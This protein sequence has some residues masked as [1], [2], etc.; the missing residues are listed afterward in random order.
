[1]K[2]FSNK[3]PAVLNLPVEWTDEDWA[4]PLVVRTPATP[5]CRNRFAAPRLPL[6]R[7]GRPASRYRQGF[8][9]I[10]LLVVISIIALLAALL[11]PVL[12]KVKEKSKITL[13]R[14]DMRTI[15]S[16]IAQYQA[17]YSVAPTP[18]PL[19][20]VDPMLG[21]DFSFNETNSD[22]I[23]ILMDIDALANASHARNPQKHALLNAP[24]KQNITGQGVSTI[25]YNFRDPWGNPYVIAFDLDF[26]NAVAVTNSP[27]GQNTSFQPLYIYEP[28]PYT[29][30][31]RSTLIW[32]LGPDGQ[33]EKG[34]PGPT[35]GQEPKN[36]DNIKGWQ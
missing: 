28:Y 35:L 11:L 23:V 22:V 26:D 30:I 34:I 2:T 5:T 33:A 13:A 29:R 21:S 9:L 6:M 16:A 1:M 24:L 31:P 18:K 20:G 17:T 7:V 3:L 25:D 8:T 32:S 12:A 4:K 10:E 36:K 19:P 15:E 14:T 27:A